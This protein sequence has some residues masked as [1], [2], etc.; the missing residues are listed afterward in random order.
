[1]GNVVPNH[2]GKR[3]RFPIQARVRGHWVLVAA[4][5]FRIGPNGTAAVQWLDP[6]RGYSFRVRNIFDG[7]ADHLGDTSAW[8]YFRVT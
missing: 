5:R 3:L 4:P 6:V 8:V 1:V 7:D 2:A